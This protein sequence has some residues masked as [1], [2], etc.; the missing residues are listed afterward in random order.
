[1][2]D[3]EDLAHVALA[4][5]AITNAVAATN[6]QLNNVA[7]AI[8]AYKHLQ[9]NLVL[10]CYR[11]RRRKRT[12]RKSWTLPRPK[13][14]W[15]DETLRGE[16]ENRISDAEFKQRLRVNRD[17]FSQLVN[18]CQVN[19]C[20]RQTRMRD[21]LSPED[22]LAIALFRLGCGLSHQ[23]CANVFSLGKATAFEASSDVISILNTLRNNYIRL[24][25]TL[26][27]KQRAVNTFKSRTA[28]PNVLGAIDCFH[29]KIKTPNWCTNKEK[30]VN[31]RHGNGRYEVACQAIVDGEMKFMHVIPGLPGSIE[32]PSDVLKKTD[33]WKVLEGGGWLDEP[34]MDVG[35]TEISPY[36]TGDRAYPLTR[37]IMK[38]FPIVE[39]VVRSE[40]T[41]KVGGTKVRDDVS[42]E[43]FDEELS[44]ASAAAQCA[45]AALQSRFRVLR[46]ANK[47]KL[48]TLNATVVACCVLHNIC[49]DN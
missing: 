35:G 16:G 24:P 31:R 3:E 29:V 39:K 10:H 42:R 49:I 12:V 19:I 43:K 7:L 32:N 8:T 15:L 9:S 38:P 21:C 33:I 26:V 28:L 5:T 20:R 30:Y 40:L 44:K 22:I 48:N 6:Q 4:C 2:E 23:A 13:S 34:K 46:K 36:L 47:D 14:S 41:G 1:M 27:D 25:E 37:S 11:E 17:T 18:I 45:F